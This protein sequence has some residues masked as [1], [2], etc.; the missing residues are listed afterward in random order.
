MD[1]GLGPAASSV[2]ALFTYICIS[3]VLSHIMG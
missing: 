1:F 3:S 2:N